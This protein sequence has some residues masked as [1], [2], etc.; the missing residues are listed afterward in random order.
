VSRPA[1]RVRP[2]GKWRGVLIVKLLLA[3]IRPTKLQAVQEALKAVGV[4]RM[5]V[6]DAHG[7]GRQR[8]Q[9]ETYRGVEYKINLLRKVVLEVVVN[10]DFVDRTIETIEQVAR[11]GTEGNIGDGKIFQVPVEQSIRIGDTVHGPEAV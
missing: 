6:C 3:I 5:T 8:G 4:E 1:T 10:D 2:D 7:Y 9:S 11:T